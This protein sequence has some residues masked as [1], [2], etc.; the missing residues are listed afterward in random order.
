MTAEHGMR[1]Q[2]TMQGSLD[3]TFKSADLSVETI[4]TL[5]M[6]LMSGPDTGSREKLNDRIKSLKPNCNTLASDD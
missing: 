4:E 5:P 1:T 3:E 6:I 2:G